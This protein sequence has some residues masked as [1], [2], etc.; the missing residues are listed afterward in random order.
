M[1][2]SQLFCN[3]LALLYLFFFLFATVC[4]F[5]QNGVSVFSVWMNLFR[6]LF[7]WCINNNNNKK[8]FLF[9][10]KTR[11]DLW[12]LH[13]SVSSFIFSTACF[14]VD[15]LT[16]EMDHRLEKMLLF[17]TGFFFCS[18]QFFWFKFNNLPTTLSPWFTNFKSASCKAGS[19]QVQVIFLDN[20]TG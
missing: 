3:E 15:I 4:C 13:Y 19:C 20:I 14:K 16:A 8:V 12:F 10:K 1:Y 7:E 2:R 11:C 18:M 5:S 6:V 9:S 17:C